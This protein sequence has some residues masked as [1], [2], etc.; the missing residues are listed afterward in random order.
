M[1]GER[2]VPAEDAREHGAHSKPDDMSR[3]TGGDPTI[4]A[5]G[6]GRAGRADDPKG[7]IPWI[8]Y[9]H[10]AVLY[11]VWSSTYLAIRIAVREGSGF[12]PFAM[13][14]RRI[15]AAGAMLLVFAMLRRRNLRIS[16]GDLWV[17]TGAAILLWV[18]GNGLVTW[19]EQF[20]HSGYAA[21]LIGALPIWTAV[22][23]AV[24]DRRLPSGRLAAALAIGFAG[25]GLLT[26]PELRMASGAYLV[27]VIAL[28]IAPISWGMGAVLQGRK[29]P[30]ASALVSASYQQMIGGVAFLLLSAAV[31]EPAPH[32]A[33]DAFW[34]WLY[35][36]IVGGAAFYSF[37]RAVQLLPTRVV[38]TYAYV[39]PVGAAILGAIVLDERITWWTVAGGALVLAG[40]AGV[41]RE[42]Y[43]SVKG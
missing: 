36:V 3:S 23:E 8:A 20:A 10:L 9:W 6:V 5:D 39:N 11:V 42:R 22:I 30:S 15:L 4:R 41:F 40:V 13:S 26:L 34:A 24:I 38:M 33:P 21:L 29:K 35:L 17:I 25:V 2:V 19:A 7:P 32:P 16:T 37:V 1:S 18:G 43:G 14:G 27:A 12:P 28:V 31:G